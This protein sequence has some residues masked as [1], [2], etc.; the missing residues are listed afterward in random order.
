MKRKKIRAP[1]EGASAQPTSQAQNQ[2]LA[3]TTTTLRPQVSDRGERRSGPTAQPRRKML[4]GMEARVRSSPGARPNSRATLVMAGARMD[5]A[6]GDMKVMQERAET[7]SHL[8]RAL[9]LRG[10]SGSS[11]PS[12]PTTP[13]A[14]SDTGMMTAGSGGDGGRLLLSLSCSSAVLVCRR[15]RRLRMLRCVW[16]A[17]D[18][19]LCNLLTPRSP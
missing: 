15:E 13:L 12:Q 17:S 7:V 11:W 4:T 2:A 16:L 18:L 3:A 9:K 1:S 10:M 19:L 8:R 6:K 5:E 14:R